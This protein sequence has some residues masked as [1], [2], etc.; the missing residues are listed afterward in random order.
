[1]S[2]TDPIGSSSPKIHASADSCARAFSIGMESKLPMALP[3]HHHYD[4]HSRHRRGI[5]D[6]N[7]PGPAIANYGAERPLARASHAMSLS[8]I[9]QRG[10]GRL[11]RRTS[12]A[13]TPANPLPLRPEAFG[14]EPSSI[15]SRL[16]VVRAI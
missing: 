16:G 11:R 14:P 6:D 12:I 5:G 3:R 2:S 15:P 7:P 4:G 10:A 1:M 8:V 13:A 9:S